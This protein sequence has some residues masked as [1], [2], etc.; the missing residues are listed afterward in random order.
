MSDQLL[1]TKAKFELVWAAMRELGIKQIDVTFSGEGDS[2]SINDVLVGTSTQ[3]TTEYGGMAWAEM[4]QRL[5]NCYVK[6]HPD[7]PPMKL[8]Q[9][10]ERLLDPMT[11][12]QNVD[13]WNNDG[14]FGEVR[15]ILNEGDEPPMI[16]LD[17]S[18]RVVNTIDHSW[19]FDRHGEEVVAEPHDEDVPNG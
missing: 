9:L 10:I 1:S 2:G 13:W 12:E 3:T 5:E 4:N 7:E 11:T 16:E 6:V 18:E 17:I 19:Q 14:G 15:L 8:T